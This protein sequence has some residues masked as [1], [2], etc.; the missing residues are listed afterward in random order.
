MGLQSAVAT[1]H[2][3]EASGDKLCDRSVGLFA[4]VEEE[5]LHVDFGNALRR[6][7]YVGGVYG[8]VGRYH[9]EFLDTVFSNR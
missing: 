7:R 1:E 4:L 5:R 2:V 3:A 9:N 8:L 6:T